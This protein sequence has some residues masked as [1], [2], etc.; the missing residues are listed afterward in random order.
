MFHVDGAR[1]LQTSLGATESVLN[2]VELFNSKIKLCKYLRYLKSRHIRVIPVFLAY[3]HRTWL[4][5]KRIESLDSKK[6]IILLEL[7]AGCVTPQPS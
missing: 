2:A 4:S 6:S 3:S 5:F 1:G 7:S